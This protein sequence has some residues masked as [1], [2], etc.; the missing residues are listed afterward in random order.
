MDKNDQAVTYSMFAYA[1][2]A[3]VL[4]KPSD[5]ILCITGAS[6]VYYFILI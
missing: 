4:M 3:S 1:M 5:I 6:F 2:L